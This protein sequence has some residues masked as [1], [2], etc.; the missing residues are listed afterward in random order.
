MLA[1]LRTY[2]DRVLALAGEAERLLRGDGPAAAQ[3]L[4]QL[5]VE[6]GVAIAAYQLFVHREIFAPMI[7]EGTPDEVEAAK[8]LKVACIAFSNQF[9][10]HVQEWTRRDPA[11]EWASYRPAALA[12]VAELQGHIAQVRSAFLPAS[13]R[14]EMHLSAAGAVAAGY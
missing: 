7:R 4:A 11:R 8:Q 12:M 14:W 1:R 6:Q 13:E 2:Q 9:C 3:R 10:H 5:R